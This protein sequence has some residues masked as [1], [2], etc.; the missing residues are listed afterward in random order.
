MMILTWVRSFLFLFAFTISLTV[1]ANEKMPNA[2]VCQSFLA[3]KDVVALESRLGELIKLMGTQA[4]YSHPDYSEVLRVEHFQYLDNE[5][6]NLAE[7]VLAQINADPGISNKIRWY[8]E[9]ILMIRDCKEI[10]S[11]SFYKWIEGNLGVG[12]FDD[13]QSAMHGLNVDKA[14]NHTTTH[15]EREVCLENMMFRLRSTRE[16]MQLHFGGWSKNSLIASFAVF[17]L[18][19]HAEI[20][21][22]VRD[23]AREL[24]VRAKLSEFGQ[25]ILQSD[26]E[27]KKRLAKK[28][29]AEDYRQSIDGRMDYI[30][31][32][33]FMV[34]TC[35]LDRVGDTTFF[36]TSGEYFNVKDR[37]NRVVDRIKN[38]IKE[39]IRRKKDRVKA[40]LKF[41]AMR[42]PFLNDSLLNEGCRGALVNFTRAVER[43]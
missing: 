19:N 13:A 10:H 26:L 17:A 42:V 38:R 23:P 11:T 40:E 30:L 20:L 12:L 34:E 27:A 39:P 29:E 36:I 21:D 1:K 9:I 3:N 25:Y 4:I 33:A 35:Y 8:A 24:R 7:L 41:S 5:K 31:E 18:P 14:C 28:K 2:N 43:L 32:M 16:K 15:L 37:L 22:Q 6:R